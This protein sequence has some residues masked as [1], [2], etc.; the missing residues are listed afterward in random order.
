MHPKKTSVTTSVIWRPHNSKSDQ[1]KYQP[2]LAHYSHL[3]HCLRSDVREVPL[4]SRRT[5]RLLCHSPPDHRVGFH[6][7]QGLHTQTANRKVQSQW[8]WRLSEIR[9]LLSY[10]LSRS[11]SVK[12]RQRN[13]KKVQRPIGWG[14]LALYII[15]SCSV[16]VLGYNMR[17]CYFICILV[18]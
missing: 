7:P 5:M 11:N 18:T 4:T 12:N 8:K 2:D 16:T 14:W 17:L 10:N 1:I 13:R 9:M 3:V 15:L 6:N